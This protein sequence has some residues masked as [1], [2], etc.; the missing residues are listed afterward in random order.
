MSDFNAI[1]MAN[2]Q[3]LHLVAEHGVSTLLCPTAV[4]ISWRMAKN[5]HIQNDD[6]TKADISETVSFLAIF[7][8]KI[9]LDPFFMTF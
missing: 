8:G 4:S 3:N 1:F 2:L 9:K 5:R 6:A 7:V